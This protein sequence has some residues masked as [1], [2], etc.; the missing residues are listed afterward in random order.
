[1][2]QKHKHNPIL[3]PRARELRKNM[4]PQEKKL[5]Y[6]FLKKFQVRFLR[7]KV[8]DQFIVDFYCFAA[9]LV[10]EI[11]GGQHM[12]PEAIAYDKERT[13]IFNGFNIHV[14]RFK[15]SDIDNHFNEVCKHISNEVENRL[16]FLSAQLAN[17]D[18]TK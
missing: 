8:I 11:D 12:I 17:I 13:D 7:Q 18:V 14:I 1:M 15:N 4:T 10:I 6:L 2:E 9:K 3:T 16:K 5:W